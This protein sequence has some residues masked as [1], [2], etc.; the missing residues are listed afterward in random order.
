M[1][2]RAGLLIAIIAA[3]CC[4][5][6]PA[7]A[8]SGFIQVS[9]TIVDPQGFP[10]AGGATGTATISAVLVPPGVNS[11]TLNGNRFSTSLATTALDSEGHFL[12]QLADNTLVQPSGTQWKFTVFGVSGL[13]FPMGRGAQSFTVTETIHGNGSTQDISTDMQAAALSLTNV[14]PNSNITPPSPITCGNSSGGGCSLTGTT[15]F[16]ILFNIAGACAG[17]PRLLWYQQSPPSS[18]NEGIYTGTPFGSLPSFFS[19]GYWG[20][21]PPENPMPFDLYDMLPSTAWSFGVARYGPNIGAGGF[22]TYIDDA[23]CNGCEAQ[24]MEVDV[25]AHLTSNT[26][27][28]TIGIDIDATQTGIG[29]V[30]Q[31]E[32]IKTEWGATGGVPN[33]VLGNITSILI[34]PPGLSRVISADSVV[35]IAIEYT[36]ARCGIDPGNFTAGL[37]IGGASV[38]PS[39]CS[40]ALDVEHG[41]VYLGASGRSDVQISGLLNLTQLSGSPG[42]PPS[43]SVFLFS[44]GPANAALECLNAAGNCTLISNNFTFEQLSAG[45]ATFQMPVNAQAYQTA[46]NCSSSASPA[47]C[48]SAAA[49]SVVVAA[50]ATTVVVDTTA[51]DANS[52]IFVTFDSSLGTKLG[53]TCNTT[54]PALYGISARNAGVSFTITSTAP[55]ANPACFSYLIVN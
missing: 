34:Q 32:N 54:E 13:P 23:T 3:L 51:V 20:E 17:D 33:E 27:L 16:E 4:F 1:S 52:Q 10:Y 21:T 6:L 36:G 11:P 31:I 43:G 2:R 39:V 29:K 30:T 15:T 26:A 49:G 14:C 24:A 37:L 8:Q 12:I 28:E 38:V 18:S 55:T 41:N 47:V 9:G 50:S 48:S 19:G 46:V 44:G 7:H 40:A 42:T 35:G 53:V 5:A 25:L 45:L 22:V